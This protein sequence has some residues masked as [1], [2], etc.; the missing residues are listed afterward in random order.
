MP[1]CSRRSFNAALCGLPFWLQSRGLAKDIANGPW[2]EPAVVA[3][4]YLISKEVHWPRPDLNVK[5]EI[6][7][8]EARLAEVGSRNAKDFKFVGGDVLATTE[9]IERW[10][11]SLRDVDAVLMMPV[12][13]P[14]VPV[15]AVVNAS[16][17]PSLCFSRPYAG[18]QWSGIANL[19]KS[20]KKVDVIATTSYGDLD[21]YAPIFRTIHHLRKSKMI[22]ASAKF[23]RYQSITDGF[24]Q[25][26]GTENGFY[27]Y[28]DLTAA[29]ERVDK[30]LAEREARDFVQN[31]FRVV[32]PKPEEITGALRFYLAAQDILERE[33][34][35]AI[36]VD[37]FPGILQKKMPAYPC[38][39]WS[40][41]NDRGMYGV[42]ESDVR[43]TMT[44]MLVTSFS[45]MPGF[46]SDP[47]FDTSR[48]EVIHA[49]C[50]AATKMKGI[51]GPSAPYLVR[52]HLETAE[53]A[54]MQV[55]MPSG[56]T[57]TV[58]EFADPKKMLVSTAEVTGTSAEV[59][60]NPDAERGCRSKI[61]T[62]VTD[63]Q[64]WLDNYSSGLH[65][66]IFY[67][68]HIAG[69]EKMGHLMGFEV[70]REM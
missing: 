14:S 63:A 70:V 53:G 32:E 36:T 6:E 10:A 2:S 58:A 24:K 8:I 15:A 33:K 23:D 1:D 68:N 50:V 27:T 26:F 5:Q 31:A 64:K 17:L 25:Q 60:G 49:H 44:Q 48:N 21:N 3:K 54:S 18:H 39:A 20:G 40:K 16:N 9:D 42:C 52:H 69:I 35:N 59:T 56:E 4:A 11:K 37:C 51:N 45:G 29:F 67:G 22:V 55:L 13:Q 66:V 47:V 34:A 46:V 19:R 12:T 62:R 57:I 30:R 61:R 38:I 7:G 43:S 41:L 28:D 65:R